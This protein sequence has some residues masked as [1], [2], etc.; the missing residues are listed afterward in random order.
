MCVYERQSIGVGH[1]ID[2]IKTGSGVSW[3]VRTE[4]ACASSLA[5]AEMMRVLHDLRC[6]KRIRNA[7]LVS[8]PSTPL[9]R[10]VRQVDRIYLPG[11]KNA[12]GTM[13]ENP[14]SHLT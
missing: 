13:V 14:A 6:C 2:G 10:N 7:D 3:A 12:G 9:T 8:Q 4:S 5:Q 11:R 1:G